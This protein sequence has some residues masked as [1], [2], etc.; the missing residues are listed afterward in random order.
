MALFNRPGSRWGRRVSDLVQ[1]LHT[2]E[3]N[4]I[5]KAGMTAR[6]MPPVPTALAEISENYRRWLGDQLARNTAPQ[7][8][9]EALK[10]AVSEARMRLARWPSLDRLSRNDQNS[11]DQAGERSPDRKEEFYDISKAARILDEQ[12]FFGNAGPSRIICQRIW[13][14]AAYLYGLV[15]ATE[16]RS[17]SRQSGRA[18]GTVPYVDWEHAQATEEH[19]GADA[20]TPEAQPTKLSLYN[21]VW[22]RDELLEEAWNVAFEDRGKIRKIWEVGTETVLVQTA[23]QL[24]GDVITRIAQQLA[25][26]DPGNIMKVHQQSIE[27]AMGMWS[28]IIDAVIRFVDI[29]SRRAG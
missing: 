14:N 22:I 24:E 13:R 7:Q 11:R 20:K 5:Q 10:S 21:L 15:E 12:E 23:I 16:K 9:N 6:R 2:L 8:N 28:S 1:D 3:V 26:K 18:I 29:V 19:P 4:T 27:T 25:D 17:A